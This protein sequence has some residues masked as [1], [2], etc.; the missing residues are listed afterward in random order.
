MVINIT[1]IG[2]AI[3]STKSKGLSTPHGVIGKM[4]D[5]SNNLTHS[6]KQCTS[7]VH[8]WVYLGMCGNSHNHPPHICFLG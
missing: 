1:T 8:N 7:K 4:L 5:G 2:H 3:R 6:A